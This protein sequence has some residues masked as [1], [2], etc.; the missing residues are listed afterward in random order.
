MTRQIFFFRAP[1]GV[2]FEGKTPSALSNCQ[3]HPL[4]PPL[5]GPSLWAPGLCLARPLASWLKIWSPRQQPLCSPEHP[6]LHPIPGHRHRLSP[7]PGAPHQS[8]V[9]LGVDGRGRDPLGSSRAMQ[10]IGSPSPAM[11]AGLM[12][13]PRVSKTFTAGIHFH[14][15]GGA[16]WQCLTLLMNKEELVGLP[17]VS[18]YKSGL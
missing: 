6:L 8:S 2:S 4:P 3:P 11:C 17:K 7:A 12:P 18:K 14:F 10:I 1:R 13:P 5:Q 9:P 16:P 15:L